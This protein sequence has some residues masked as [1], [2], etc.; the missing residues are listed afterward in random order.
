[1]DKAPKEKNSKELTSENFVEIK[2]GSA[3][4]KKKKS[5]TGT[6]LEWQIMRRS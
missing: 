5:V 3:H 4:W 6:Y 1:M 2:L